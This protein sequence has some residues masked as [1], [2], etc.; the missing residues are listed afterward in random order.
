MKKILILIVTFIVLLTFT[1][2]SSKFLEKIDYNTLNEKLNNKETFVLYFYNDSSNLET[3]LTNVLESN[4]LIGYKINTS[5]ITNNEKL[6]L[7]TKIDYKNPCVVF[8]LNGED[9]SILSHITDENATNKRIEDA[10]KDM[11]FIK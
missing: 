7:Q 2:C 10:L 8:I 6:E 4:N 3:T 5:K 1:G 9:P 11:N